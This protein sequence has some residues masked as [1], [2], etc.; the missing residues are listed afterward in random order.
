MNTL[1]SRITLQ[2]DA[3]FHPHQRIAGIS[4]AVSA[5]LPKPQSR[6]SRVYF[7]LLFVALTNL[8]IISTS[9][10]AGKDAVSSTFPD[11]RHEPIQ[12]LTQPTGLDPR[13]V[14][15]GERLFHDPRLGRD[16]DMSCSSCHDLKT[17]GTDRYAHTPGRDGTTLDVNTLTIFN[18]SLNHRL[19]W[20]GR[21]L[22]L[23]E[24]I[25]AVVA[26]SKELATSWPD[27]IDKLKQDEKYRAHF[28]SLYP[29]GITAKNVRNAIATFER[30]LITL[31]SPFDRFLLGDADAISPEAKTGYELFKTYGCIACHQG[32][33]VGGNL[34]MKFGVFKDYFAARGNPTQADLGRFNVTGDEKDRHVF[35]VPSLRLVSLTP[36][37]FH[38][39]TVDTLKEAVKI[40]AKHQLGR[41]IPEADIQRIVLFLKT[42]PGKYRGQTLTNAQASTP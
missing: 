9:V 19:F 1:K 27:I 22:G 15:L 39:G 3:Q 41:S 2:T 30:S 12:P 23:E 5:S 35:R 10:F 25:N 34:F 33:N 13:K 32:S 29:D 24:Q 36:P 11:L 16:N 28:Q 37:Y 42:L 7:T 6:K 8:S 18:S 26:S 17:N 40:M 4:Q 20:D 38:D 31:D 14:S 21:A